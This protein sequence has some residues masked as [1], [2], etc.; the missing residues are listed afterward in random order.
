MRVA[1]VFFAVSL[2]ACRDVEIVDG[3]GGSSSTSTTSTSKTTVGTTTST[4]SGTTTVCGGK[5]GAL[6]AADEYCDFADGSCGVADQTGVCTPKP[7]GCTADC[8]GVCACDGSFYCNACGA[9]EDGLDVSNSTAC[10]AD[11]AEYSAKLW[12]GDLDHL[13][14]R[15]ADFQRDLCFEL[16]LDAPLMPQDP[17]YVQAPQSY[18]ATSG[19]VIQG[20]MNCYADV[21]PDPLVI[22]AAGGKGIVDWKLGAMMFYPCELDIDV[23]LTFQSTASWLMPYE[24]MHAFGVKVEDTCL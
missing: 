12:I 18:V 5:T 9:A 10:L 4:A 7:P 6:C 21:A 14:V 20:A 19:I 23:T 15:K 17:W 13:V 11:N 24:T 1:C 8:P 2:I 22:Q 16:F 3:T